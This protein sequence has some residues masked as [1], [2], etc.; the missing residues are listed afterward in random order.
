MEPHDDHPSS[1]PV[2][3]DLETYDLERAAEV[4]GMN[5]GIILELV[6]SRVV[7]FIHTAGPDSPIF[8]SRAIYRLRQIAVLRE[9]STLHMHSVCLI[10]GL[11]ER[12]EAAERELRAL[13]EKSV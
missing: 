13:R 2:A 11:M 5:P 3:D 1:F 6:E 12:L 9:D 7:S 8:D 4:S 10:I